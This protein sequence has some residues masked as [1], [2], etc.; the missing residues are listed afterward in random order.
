MNIHCNFASVTQPDG[1]LSKKTVC[2]MICFPNAK[3]NLGLYITE[4]RDD[5]YHNL[6]T[7]FLPIPLRDVLEIKPLNFYDSEYELQ[8]AGIH[9]DGSEKENLVVRVFLDMKHEFDLPPQT[10][11]LYKRI[12]T[13]A[14]LGGGSSDAAFMMRLLN[15]QFRL[16]L[17][18]DEMERRMSHY[19]ADCPF[20]VRDE[21]SLATGI[22]DILTPVDIDLSGLYL[23]L[24]KPSVAV[25]TRDAYARVTPKKPAFDLV[26]SLRQPMEE[27]RRTIGNDFERSVFTKYPGIAA[28]KQ[29]MYD[30]HALYA[31]MSGSGSS[32]FGLFRYPPAEAEEV[33]KDCF[34][35][36][37]RISNLRP[38]FS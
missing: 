23:L 4:K 1:C 17:S 35:F 3:I 27:W 37:K 31:S 36:Q 13:G 9:I 10:I 22:G 12:P 8:Q 25:A 28:I 14:G 33:F 20:F 21:P 15:E 16:G 29:T 6:E 30:M 26:K 11:Y 24:V 7:V 34:V 38:T 19:G 32:V 2:A 5:G 18:N